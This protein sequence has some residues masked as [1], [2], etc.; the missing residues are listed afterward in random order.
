MIHSACNNCI[1]SR[2]VDGISAERQHFTVVPLCVYRGALV[3]GQQIFDQF[4]P[5]NPQTNDK[6]SDLILIFPVQVL[7]HGKYDIGG[8]S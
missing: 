8:M 6:M 4:S 7:I 2:K 5:G 1:N 3:M